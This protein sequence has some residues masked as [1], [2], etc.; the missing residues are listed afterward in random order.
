MVHQG[1]VQTRP[2]N[3][4]RHIATK[5]SPRGRQCARSWVRHYSHRTD[6]R[7]NDTI[8]T[9]VRIT[10]VRITMV[11][12]MVRVMDSTPAEEAGVGAAII[13]RCQP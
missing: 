2:V 7:E 11:R 5:T 9:M 13:A 10:M 12:A 4:V 1:V 6:R 8:I 3:D